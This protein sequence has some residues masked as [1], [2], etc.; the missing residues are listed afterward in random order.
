MYVGRGEERIARVI[1]SPIIAESDATF[2]LSG[3]GVCDAA[4]DL[5]TKKKG[6][7]EDE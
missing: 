4:S 3:A 7:G 5:A 1:D 6:G 2:A